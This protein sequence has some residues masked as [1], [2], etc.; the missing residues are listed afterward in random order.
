M[1]VEESGFYN[2]LL[3][4]K[5][6]LFLCHRNA[7]PD[8][9]GSAYT[10][11]QAFGGVVGIVDGCNRVASTLIKTLDIE[12]IEK[13]DPCDYDFTVVV[14]TSTL[15]QLNGIELTEYAVI[16]HH[17]TCA[18]KDGAKF[19]LQRNVSS[20]AEIVFDILKYMEAPVMRKSAMMLIAGLITDTGNFKYATHDSFRALAEIIETSGVEYGEVVDLLASTPQDISMRIALLKAAMRAQVYRIGDWLIVTSTISSFGGTAASTLTHVGADVS[21]VGAD[22]DGITRISSRARRNAI[23]AGVNLGQ[24]LEDVSQQFNGT[25]GGHDGAAGLDV[26][27]GDVQEILKSCVDAT[28]KK[29][30]GKE[31]R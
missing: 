5:N 24:I 18:L 30:A 23:E 17:S 10:L 19:Y 12:A 1:E 26:E 2:R 16:D 8:A 21:F 4:Y 3:D 6:I 28:T 13:P 20:T 25:G 15:A 31:A 29:L 27:G 11:A 22:K 9:V 14:D 7:D